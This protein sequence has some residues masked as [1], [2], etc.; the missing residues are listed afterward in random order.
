MTRLF[1]FLA[2]WPLFLLQAVGAV[3]GWTVW[4]ASPAY[5]QRFRAN[6]AQAGISFSAARPAIA[7]AG[8]FVA[9]LPKLWMRPS[10]QSCLG[11]VV[12]EGVAHAEAAFA[13]GKGVIFFAPHCGCFELEPQVLAF[14]RDGVLIIFVYTIGVQVGL[15]HVAPKAGP[16][17]QS[18]GRGDCAPRS[19]RRVAHRVAR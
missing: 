15:L 18:H 12:V 3:L 7:G 8:R 5:R 2:L 4:C 9:E 6:V 13:Q 1:R 11:N 19:G 10:G 17:A 14:A 16:S